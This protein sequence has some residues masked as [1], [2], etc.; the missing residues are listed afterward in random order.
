M[1]VQ[2]FK[3]HCYSGSM[4]S[5]FNIKGHPV[6][7]MLVGFPV[8]FFFGGFLFDIFALIKSNQEFSR[9]ALYLQVSGL[10]FGTLA[11]IPGIFDYFF[12]ITARSSARKRGMKHGL[13]NLSVLIIFAL[14]VFLRYNESNNL[15]LFL[16]LEAVGLVLLGISGWMGATLVVRNQIGIDH[17]YAGAGKWK[18]DYINTTEHEIELKGLESL[19]VDQMKLLHIN[20][21]RIV[22]ARTESGLVAFEDFCSH[23]GASLADGVLICGHVQCPL[24]GSQFDVQTGKVKAGPA[25]KDIACFALKEKAN[26]VYLELEK[27]LQNAAN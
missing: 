23:R 21:H 15:F 18:E 10:L 13:I 9:M 6:H 19:K 5:N 20:R 27:S 26:A 2:V 7:P 16:C 22:I 25:E 1:L 4:K 8:A 24:H 11:A 14:V 3:V 12:S 17:R